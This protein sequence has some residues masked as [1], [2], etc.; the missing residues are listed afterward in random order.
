MKIKRILFLFK[1]GRENL[2]GHNDYFYGLSVLLNNLLNDKYEGK[3]IQFINI[4]FF[5]DKTYEIFPDLQKEKLSFFIQ[6]LRYHGFFNKEDLNKLNP[7]EKKVY[8]WE[9]ACKYLCDAAETSNNLQLYQAVKYVYPEGLKKNLVTDYRTKSI[10]IEI[11]GENYLAS[12]WIC[13]L[14]TKMYSK[15]TLEKNNIITFEKNIDETKSGIEFFLEIYKN[16]TADNDCITI[17]GP[18]DVDYLPLKIQFNEMLNI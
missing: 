18:K 13:F 17:H 16:I 11:K 3:K 4:D 2:L 14:E 6:D 5:T 10:D 15:F 7:S 1:D 8:I 9:K 12:V